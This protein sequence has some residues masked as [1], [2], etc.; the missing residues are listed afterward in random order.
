MIPRLGVN[1]DHVATVR[2]ARGGREPDPV[3]A[4]VEAE[5]GGAD[6]ITIHLRE[7]RRHIQDRD[8]RL[9]KE[10]VQTRLN[11]ELALEPGDRGPGVGG[12]ARSGDVRA[13]ASPGADDRRG[14]RRDRP[15]GPGGRGGPPLPR[16]GPDR[17]QPVHRPGRGPG[18]AP[19]PSWGSMRSN[20]TPGGTPTRP[21][22]RGAPRAA[23]PGRG[24]PA[25]GRGGDGPPRR[26]R[27]EPGQRR[28][29]G[30]DR[31][32]GRAEHRP[33][34]HRPGRS[35]SGSGPPSAR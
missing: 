31:P 7:D 3:W 20:C 35:S 2:Q 25:R 6:G 9:L 28:R 4:A 23:S 27:P 17:R 16:C 14:P 24:R 30:P 33:Q 12:P 34:P 22:G 19:R 13:R 10:T 15:A 18:R 5:L 21:T 26:P 1:I 11:L 32:D 29:R 8:L